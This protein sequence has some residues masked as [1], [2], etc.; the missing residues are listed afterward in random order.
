MFSI[1]IVEEKDRPKELGKARSNE[2][3]V[4]VYLLI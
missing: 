2:I 1:K 4:T 3:G